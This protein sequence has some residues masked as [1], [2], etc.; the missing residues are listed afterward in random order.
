MKEEKVKEDKIFFRYSD[1]ELEK[2]RQI[3]LEKL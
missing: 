3:I 2:F 1:V